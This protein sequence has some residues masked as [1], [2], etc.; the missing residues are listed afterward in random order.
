MYIAICEIAHQSKFNALNRAL[1]VGAL[2]QPRGMGWGKEV[3][4]GFG[5]GDTGT[6]VAD[7]CQCM[8]KTT[9]VL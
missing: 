3:G 1:Q 9:T 4:G 7:S 6:P 8:A 5:M 2:G